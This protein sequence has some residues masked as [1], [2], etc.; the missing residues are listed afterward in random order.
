MSI[1]IF[2]PST[3]FHNC[4][5]KNYSVRRLSAIAYTDYLHLIKKSVRLTKSH[6]ARIF[7]LLATEP[8]FKSH[9][10]HFLGMKS[11]N[12]KNT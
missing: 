9:R 10:M 5:I 4:C 12:L 3:S 7:L 8:A 6:L 11:R 2:S 1:R